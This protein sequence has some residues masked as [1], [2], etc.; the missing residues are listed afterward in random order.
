MC[1][2]CA[3]QSSG[4]MSVSGGRMSVSARGPEAEEN[5]AESDA[6]KAR[7]RALIDD[8]EK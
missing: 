2:L 8:L 5:S 7:L 3:T 1:L 6:R 4:R